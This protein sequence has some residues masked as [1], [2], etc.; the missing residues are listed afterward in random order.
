V[1]TDNIKILLVDDH[2]VVRAGFRYLLEKQSGFE[3]CEAGSAEDA[4]S[5]CAEIVPDV[6]V[7]DI[8]MPGMGGLECIRRLCARDKNIRILVLSMY[9]DPSFVTRASKMGAMGYLSKNSAPE[10][11]SKAILAVM[12]NKKYISTDISKRARLDHESGTGRLYGLSTREFQIFSLL[13]EGRSAIAIADSLNISPKTVHNHRSHIMEKLGLSN[14][15]EITRLAIRQG[16]I[17]A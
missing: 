11:L 16:I 14:T 13:A 12:A 15:S 9:D 3:V 2:P 17:D 8:S 5:L 1:K 10:E 7:L 4:Y 6:V